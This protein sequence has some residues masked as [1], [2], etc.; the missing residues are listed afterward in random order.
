MNIDKIVDE[1]HN[2]YR[3]MNWKWGFFPVDKIPTREDIRNTILELIESLEEYLKEEPEKYPMISTGGI[4]IL[5]CGD[6]YGIFFGMWCVDS[7]DLFL[8]KL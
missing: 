7:E 3:G 4:T 2:I 1:L 6:E 5:K 8:E